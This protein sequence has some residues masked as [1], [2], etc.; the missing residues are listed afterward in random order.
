MS[1]V[2]TR[3]GSKFICDAPEGFKLFPL[4]IDDNGKPCVFAVP[5]DGMSL[6]K[7]YDL[8]TKEWTDVGF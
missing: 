4:F 8:D 6:P 2:Q 5:E 7:K 1:E 3:S